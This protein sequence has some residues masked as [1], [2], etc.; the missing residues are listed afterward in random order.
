VTFNL[1]P[2]STPF[3][4]RVCVQAADG[5]SKLSNLVC[6]TDVVR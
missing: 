1:S 6:A 2:R 3:D 5:T 4:G